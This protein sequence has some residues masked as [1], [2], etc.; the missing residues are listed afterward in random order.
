M[1]SKEADL[2]Q[3][4]AVSWDLIRQKH[5]QLRHGLLDI[6]TDVA[7]V[8]QPVTKPLTEIANKEKEN[9]LEKEFTH[10]HHTKIQS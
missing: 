5:M 3:Q 1:F 10:L 4:I 6:Q 8:L 9:K 2:L 7:R